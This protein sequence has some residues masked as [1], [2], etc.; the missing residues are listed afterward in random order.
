ML[1]RALREKQTLLETD[2]VAGA[3]N[4]YAGYR[5]FCGQI[6]GIQFAIDRIIEFRERSGQDEDQDFK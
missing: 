2:L 1:E 6:H 5:D 3:A 4:D